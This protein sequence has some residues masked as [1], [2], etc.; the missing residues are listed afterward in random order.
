MGVGWVDGW[1]DGAVISLTIE[2]QE[3]RNVHLDR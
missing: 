2:W 3:K 1:M